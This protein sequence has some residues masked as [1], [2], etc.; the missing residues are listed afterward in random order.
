MSSN[1]SSYFNSNTVVSYAEQSGFYWITFCYRKAYVLS[2]QPVIFFSLTPS[3]YMPTLYWS[4]KVLVYVVR[5]V[6]WHAQKVE[7]AASS[8]PRPQRFWRWIWWT[9][10]SSQDFGWWTR[11]ESWSWRVLCMFFFAFT[12]SRKVTHMNATLVVKSL[13]WPCSR[14][15][16][17]Q[18]F[19]ITSGRA[20]RVETDYYYWCLDRLLIKRLCLLVGSQCGKKRSTHPWQR[21]SSAPH[22]TSSRSHTWRLTSLRWWHTLIISR[23]TFGKLRS[24][25]FGYCVPRNNAISF[26]TS[27]I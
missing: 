15:F 11:A 27:G 6:F 22:R 24:P 9:P 13:A 8:P 5:C 23:W 1:L 20:N 19:K 14:R 2:F 17:Q 3:Q 12:T 4:R 25:H 26:R 16:D 10:C 18:G 21:I 7:H